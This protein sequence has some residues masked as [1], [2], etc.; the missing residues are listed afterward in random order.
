M[1]RRAVDDYDDG[2]T[3]PGSGGRRVDGV[4][5]IVEAGPERERGLAA[6]RARYEQYRGD[7]A[8]DGPLI[9]I[10]IVAIRGWS[11]I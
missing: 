11:M 6:L 1:R 4:A 2:L 10:E 5:R 7:V 9:A 3:G 8:L